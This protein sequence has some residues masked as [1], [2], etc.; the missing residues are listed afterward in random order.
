[1]DASTVRSWLVSTADADAD[2]RRRAELELKKVSGG[3]TVIVVVVPSPSLI[4]AFLR[5]GSAVGPWVDKTRSSPEMLTIP[6]SVSR[7]NNIRDSPTFF[8]TLFR[9]NRTLAFNFKVRPPRTICAATGVSLLCFSDPPSCSA[10]I[11]LK[12]RV[13][14][15]WQRQ[16]HYINEVVIPDDAKA[17]FRDRLLPIL[18][19][20]PTLVRHQLVPILQRILHFDFPE[21]WPTFM[22]YTVQL[23]NTNDAPSV[24]AGLQC[25]LAICRAY[26]FK[27]SDG[28]SRVQFDK[29]IEANFPR[30]LAIC[31]ELVNQDSDEAGEMLHIALK[32]YKHATWVRSSLPV[33]GF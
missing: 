16:E 8:S 27:A 19:A 22:D 26:R 30:L 4:A 31:N 12:N 32:S 7:A 18:A 24:Q 11:Y 20:S 15:A 21:R 28:E 5:H 23:L 33:P 25:L 13:N 14:R 9:P 6:L 3:L 17:R 10:V 29:I 2:V 1:M